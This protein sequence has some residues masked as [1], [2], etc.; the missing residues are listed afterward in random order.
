M[1]I[2]TF[3]EQ[4]HVFLN[5]LK[6]QPYIDDI[7]DIAKLKFTRKMVKFFFKS[8]KILLHSNHLRSCTK[9]EL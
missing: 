9:K 6:V 2:R 3:Y 7:L 1:S 5:D 8:N 4:K